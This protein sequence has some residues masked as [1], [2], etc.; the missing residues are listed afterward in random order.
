MLIDQSYFQ[1][2]KNQ[3][4]VN[5][6]DE[7]QYPST[8]L[9][10][11]ENIAILK[12]HGV[13][14][15]SCAY[16]PWWGEYSSC[17][18]LI[19]DLKKVEQNN[20]VDTLILDL[21]TP[22]GEVDGVANVGDF[23][24]HLSQKI[25]TM[26]IVNSMAASGGYWLA[27]AC[28]KIGLIS[29]TA[30]V[31]SVGVAV[32]HVDISKALEMQGLTIT[33]ITAGKWKRATAREMPL[34]EEGYRILQDQVDHIYTIFVNRLAKYK[35]V[36]EEEVL[37]YADGRM[38][39]GDLAIQNG[40][41]DGIIDFKKI[42]GVEPMGN[43]F[44]IFKLQEDEEASVEEHDE[45]EEMEDEDEDVT[46]QED[47]D[48]EME[49]DEEDNEEVEEDE[50]EE[51]IDVKIKR[52]K[53]SVSITK[54]NV[55][56]VQHGIRLERKRA[57]ALIKLGLSGKQLIAALVSGDDEKTVA[58]NFMK[59]GIKPGQTK[60]PKASAKKKRRKKTTVGEGY[61]IGDSSVAPSKT[62][63]AYDIEDDDIK[64]IEGGANKYCVSRNRI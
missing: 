60:K 12:I 47:E 3:C 59:A 35:G 49:E 22:G 2:L 44:N 10:I 34:E 33:H 13:L 63:N 23:I 18:I 61:L 57:T 14:I 11:E 54:K 52:K 1:T 9:R 37:K 16:A 19:N 30:S 31:G 27:S 39:I 56:F 42:I 58:Y 40:L 20:N 48:E 28:N 43:V 32:A 64:A 45:D 36:S 8:F 50:E 21:N 29:D 4:M 6:I 46:A 24:F 55:K 26:A 62:N 7:Y 5:D 25:K 15:E 38:F 41:A 53:A 51:E 17:D